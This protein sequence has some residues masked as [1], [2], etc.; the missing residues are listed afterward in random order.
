M[1]GE[2][3]YKHIYF[4]KNLRYFFKGKRV[5]KPNFYEK[6]I[7]IIKS[8]LKPFGLIGFGRKVLKTIKIMIGKKVNNSFTPS[9][10]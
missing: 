7:E 5:I 8:I 2:F 1:K 9:E 3:F 10:W 6:I 4:D